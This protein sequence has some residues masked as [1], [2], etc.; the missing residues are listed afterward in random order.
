MTTSAGTIAVDDTE[1]AGSVEIYCPFR[2]SNR[3]GTV[4]ET[5]DASSLSPFSLPA[6]SLG[7]IGLGLMGIAV[8]ERLINAGATV[9]GWDLSPERNSE[10]D[11]VGG[12]VAT[13]LANVFSRCDRVLLSLPTH[14]TV[15][16]V[17]ETASA[18]LHAGHVLID[19]STGEPAAAVEQARELS[20][21]GIEYLDATVSGSSQQLREG[22]AVFLVGATDYAYI[23]CLDIFDLLTSKSYHTGP[24]DFFE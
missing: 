9:I 17:L 24:V 22:A 18:S 21:R 16:E 23:A 19:L 12:T 14:E 7:L 8:S 2:F 4:K 20:S 15:K 5:M 3:I 6:P 10:L 11:A 13:D 1:V